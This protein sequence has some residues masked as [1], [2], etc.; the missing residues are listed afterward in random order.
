M[1][2]TTYKSVGS[3]GV[4]QTK[5][6][7]RILAA[8]WRSDIHESQAMSEKVLTNGNREKDRFPKLACT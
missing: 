3:A 4:T 6:Y 1:I 5:L 7:F 2:W 8:E